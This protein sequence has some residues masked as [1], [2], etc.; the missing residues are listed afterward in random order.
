M[1]YWF[2]CWERSA[3]LTLCA[4]CW[5]C[6][7]AE[8]DG[9]TRPDQKC[10]QAEPSAAQQ[11]AA[12]KVAVRKLDFM[13]NNHLRQEGFDFVM[14]KKKRKTSQKGESK[15]IHGASEDAQVLSPVAYTKLD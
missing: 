3:Q 12:D 11:E 9:E 5:R 6:G 14:A 13:I 10:S 2:S 7:F 4:A 15:E 8:G 1:C